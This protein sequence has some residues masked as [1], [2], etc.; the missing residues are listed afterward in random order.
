MN[1]LV[2]ILNSQKF[3]ILFNFIIPTYHN[4]EIKNKL[5]YFLK[6]III[7]L[8]YTKYLTIIALH[9]LRTNF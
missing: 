8:T 9:Y 6:I 4:K 3:K 7:I 5:S 1:N 2:Q